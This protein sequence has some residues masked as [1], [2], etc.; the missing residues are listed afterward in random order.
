MIKSL[1]EIVEVLEDLY[2]TSL[3]EDWDNVGLLVDSGSKEI[4][5]ILVTLSVSEEIIRKAEEIGATLIVSHHPLM[6]GGITKIAG[7]SRDTLLIK[8]LLKRGISLYTLHSN[9]DLHE[10]GLNYFLGQ[11][12]ELNE[13]EIL[14]P[15]EN[16]TYAKLFFYIPTEAEG[17]VLKALYELGGG[18][19]GN[20]DSCGFT[21]KGYGSFRPL[22]G[23]NPKIGQVG[24]KEILE[25]TKVEMIFPQHLVSKAIEVLKEKHPYET[26]AY[27]VFKCE[28][29]DPIHGLGVV[30]NLSE[31][32]SLEEFL[33]RVRKVFKKKSLEYTKG[34]AG[35]KIKKVAVCGGAGKDLL[36][37]AC[38]K[39][40]IYL[41]GDLKYHDFEEAFF[42]QYPLVDIGHFSSEIVALPYLAA[43]LEEKTRIK[44]VTEVGHDYVESKEDKNS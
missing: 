22:E 17:P 1:E 44:V 24:K 5:T 16:N 4:E 3:G 23:A 9:F 12:L 31:E 35:R 6:L 15:L 7:K 10:K 41:T 32:I 36:K 37:I 42:Q 11:A 43:I 38:K 25:E 20:Y 26:V 29:Q 21:T 19:M 33:K 13:L 28:G 2:P 39:S 34:V 30:G 40:D 18:K 27:E 8:E 14:A